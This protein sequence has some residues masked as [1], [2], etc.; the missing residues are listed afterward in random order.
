M[1][2]PRKKRPT[3]ERDQMLQTDEKTE[4]LFRRSKKSYLHFIQHFF[5][6][7]ISCLQMIND[8]PSTLA[9]QKYLEKQLIESLTLIDNLL[10]HLYSRDLLLDYS[11]SQTIDDGFQKEL[12]AIEMLILEVKYLLDKYSFHN[13]SYPEQ[14]D[15]LID[16]IA[17]FFYSDYVKVIVVDDQLADPWIA[18]SYE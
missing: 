15:R 3:K 11:I 16:Q 12:E 4:D 7:Q 2:F 5:K 18:F 8:L 1:V 6:L 13:D 10:M 17:K 14:S 9:D